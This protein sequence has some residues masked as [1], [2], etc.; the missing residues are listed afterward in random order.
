MRSDV[1]IVAYATIIVDAKFEVKDEDLLIT[2]TIDLPFIVEEQFYN[3][4]KLLQ[5]HQIQWK[6]D[7]V[8]GDDWW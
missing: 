3:E 5:A 8:F 7:D 4:G 6:I 1:H 2:M